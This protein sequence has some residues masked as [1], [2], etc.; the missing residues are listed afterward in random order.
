[1]GLLW[2]L[3]QQS[4]LDEQKES[5]RYRRTRRWTLNEQSSTKA[6]LI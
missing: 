2:D 5:R 1:M 6:L 4:E 3:I